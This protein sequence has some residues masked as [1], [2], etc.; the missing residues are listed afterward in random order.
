MKVTGKASTS[1]AARGRRTLVGFSRWKTL[2]TVLPCGTLVALAVSGHAR[3][4]SEQDATVQTNATAAARSLNAGKQLSH[5]N[6]LIHEKSPY[7]LLH[8]HNPVDWYPWGE[9][10]FARAKREN[11]PIFL[12]VGYY[13]CHWCHV[14]ERESYSNAR[15]AELLN[16][17]FVCVKV[18]REERPDIDS[19]YMSFVEATTGSGGWPMNVFLT[20][21]LKPFFGGTYFPPEDKYGAVGLRTLLPRIADLWSQQHQEIMGSADRITQK[22]QQTVDSGVGNGSGALPASVLDKAYEQIRFSFDLANGGFGEVPRFPRTVVPD[23]LLRYW[24]RSR[25]KDALDM[26]LDNLRSMAAGGIHDQI[27]GGFHRYSTDGQWRVPHFEKMLY[28]QAQLAMLYTEAYQAT[29]DR[30]YANVVRDILDFTVREMRSP[31][32]AFYSALDADSPLGKGKSQNG[33][34]AFYVWT[35]AEIEQVLGKKTASIFNFRYGVEPGGNVPSE[36]DIEGSLKGKNVLYENHSLG[37][38]AKK[39]GKTETRTSQ[40]LRDAKEKLFARRSLRPPPPVDTKVITSWNGLMISALAKAS[41]VL[42]EPKYLVAANRAKAFLKVRVY[43]PE[44]GKLKRRYR[45]GSADIDGYLDDYTFLNQGLLDLYEASFDVRL[46]SGIIRLQE[47]QD[48]LFWDQKLG[49]YFSTSGQDRSILLR[50]REAYDGAEPSPNSVAAMNLLRLWQITD[51]QS[52]KDKA[53]KTLLAFGP[54][55][56]QRPEAMPYM[57]SAFDFSLAKPRQIVIVGVP[58]AEDTRALLRLVWQRYIPNRVLLLADGAEGQKQLA[59]WVPSLANVKR[60]QGRATAYICENY[61]CNLPT[62][63]L[64]MVARL[65]DGS[66][67]LP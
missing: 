21:D 1:I 29:K 59:R 18:D 55:L 27:G 65:L 42:D 3:V 16:R 19:E 14:M 15:I 26:V 52:Y 54:G 38:T 20:P 58:G 50:T 30:F 56:E 33:E 40:T 49:G 37:E 4:P 9:E 11:K 67:V 66:H 57:M 22:L 2:V 28:D 64:Q 62:A 45:A 12:S 60:K 23:F 10:A 5:T 32:G 36:Q 6:R 41:Q 48:R 31:E 34:G 61:I 44:S 47:M 35:A 53:D 46:L 8:A 24:S 63:D 43:Q 39:F 51:Q 13:T 17:W 25:K 7:L